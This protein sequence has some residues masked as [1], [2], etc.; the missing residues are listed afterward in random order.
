MTKRTYNQ[1]CPLSYALD[2]IGERWTLLIA[3]ELLF[4]PRRYTDLLNGL[5]G[6]G[7]NLLASRLKSLEERGVIHQRTLPPP[8]ASK[9]Y[10]LTAYGDGLRPVL[11][12]L[13]E[14]GMNQ[15]TFPLPEEDYLG[16][17]PTMGALRTFFDPTLAQGIMLTVEIRAEDTTLALTIKDGALDVRE[18]DATLPDVI[19]ALTRKDLL[20]LLSESLTP[21]DAIQSE[22]LTIVEGDVAD[23]ARLIPLFHSHE[24]ASY[25]KTVSS[26]I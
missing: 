4:G 24:S 23:F 20:N 8:A 10:E 3:R 26:S 6:I 11:G 18:G 9:V 5:P 19:V 15:L 7:T 22:R 2:I 1:F 21:E 16:I 12:A 14:W 13:A 17:V 25:T